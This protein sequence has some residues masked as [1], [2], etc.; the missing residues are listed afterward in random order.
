MKQK[1]ALD[2]LLTRGGRRNDGVALVTALIFTSVCVLAL[3]LVS[4]RH[5]QQRTLV[6]RYQVWQTAF[7]IAESGRLASQA[8]LENSQD[9]ILGI[10]SEWVPQYDEQN[11]IVLPPFDS[12]FVDPVE[13]TVQEGTPPIT[14]QMISYVVDWASDNWD[15]N[16]DGVVDDVLENGI[17]SI[18]SASLFANHTRRVDAVYRSYDVNVWNNA[19][20]GGTGQAGGL[21][22]GNV[23]I[24]GSVHLLG[25]NL[26]PGSPA[27]IAMDLSGTSL[28]HNNYTGM[29]ANLRSMVPALPTTSVGGET[30]ETLHAVFRVKRGLVGLSGNSEIGEPNAPGNLT[31]ELMDGVFVQEGW[32]GNAVIPDGGRGIPKSVF[33]DNGHGYQYDLG[34]R[35]TMPFLDDYWREPDGSLVWNST[36]GDWYTH[37]DY[38]SQV[39]LAEAANATDGYYTGDLTIDAGDRDAFY[40]N[41]SK[42]QELTGAAALAAVPDPD[43]DYIRFDPATNLM[44]INGQ[45]RVTGN[46]V[47]DGKAN[48]KTIYYSGK[49]A[50]LVDGNVT[51]DCD[52]YTC[53][54][55]NPND[56]NLSYP[57]NCLGIMARND[58][59]VGS[60]SQLDIMGAFY[61]QGTIKTMKQTNVVGT[62]VSNYF[63]MGSQVPNIFQVPELARNLPYGMIGNYPLLV[64]KMMAWTERG[65]EP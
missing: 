26:A 28:V 38:F 21:I 22:N 60:K 7:D 57:V 20:F 39:L 10:S 33:S 41:A 50:I 30:V 5:L 27:V 61:A 58:M 11:Q 46:L 12:E 8:A 55:K 14:A 48:D 19:I 56:T 42:N 51:I 49:G 53:N 3:V 44:E 34:D 65:I 4:A 45:L 37:E 62:F 18:H 32:T 2:R 43:D 24:H 36:T 25:D 13:I 64:L 52:L 16:G 35:V 63:D 40:W 47:L 31:K 59:L 1:Q 29:P 6:D 23:S 54:N 9:G 17:F 15:N